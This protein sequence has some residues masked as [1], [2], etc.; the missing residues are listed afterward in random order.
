M[1]IAHRKNAREPIR[2]DAIFKKS[3]VMVL[4]SVFWQRKIS[5]KWFLLRWDCLAKKRKTSRGTK[6]MGTGPKTLLTH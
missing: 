2:T 5:S 1:M 3:T 6:S 4:F